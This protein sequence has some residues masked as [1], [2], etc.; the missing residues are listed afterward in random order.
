MK[1]S[2]RSIFALSLGVAAI[3]GAPAVRAGEAH[4]TVVPADKAGRPFKLLSLP[5][6]DRL[7]RR[8]TYLL[9]TA[10][11]SCSAIRCG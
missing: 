2:A 10:P 5:P 3:W 4:H 1:H 6:P 7:L 11:R 9:I 8:P